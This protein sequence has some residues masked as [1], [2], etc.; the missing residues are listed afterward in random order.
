MGTSPHFAVA[1]GGMP[2]RLQQM[3]RDAPPGATTLENASRA[4]FENQDTLLGSGKFASPTIVG[5]LTP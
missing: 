3:L 5:A 1:N 2:M 4:C